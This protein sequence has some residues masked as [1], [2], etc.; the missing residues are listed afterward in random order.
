M[1]FKICTL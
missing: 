1:E